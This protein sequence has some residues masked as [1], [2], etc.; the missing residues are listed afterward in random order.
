M[1]LGGKV[2]GIPR[3]CEQW[4]VRM[5]LVIYCRSMEETESLGLGKQRE[6]RQTAD[7]L[8]G[9]LAGVVII[10]RRDLCWDLGYSKELGEAG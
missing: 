4:E 6:S 2:C 3:R 10:N 8:P 7:N 9:F 5:H 1:K